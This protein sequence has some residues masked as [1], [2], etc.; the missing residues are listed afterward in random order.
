MRKIIGLLI[1]VGIFFGYLLPTDSVEKVPQGP[2]IRVFIRNI[3]DP[4][5][6]TAEDVFAEYL[7]RVVDFMFATL[8]SFAEQAINTMRGNTQES[9]RV[10]GGFDRDLTDEQK[11]RINQEVDED[12]DSVLH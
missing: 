10:K 1:I 7:P 2:E 12:V 3:G 8:Q 11:Q 9:L 5:K 4:V 6:A